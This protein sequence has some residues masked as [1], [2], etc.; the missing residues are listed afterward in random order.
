MNTQEKIPPLSRKNKDKAA[1]DF[2]YTHVCF[3]LFKNKQKSLNL[4]SVVI[5]AALKS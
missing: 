4:Y 3:Q 5:K 2:E 1:T